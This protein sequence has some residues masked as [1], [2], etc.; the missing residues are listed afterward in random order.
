MRDHHLSPAIGL[1]Y[2]PFSNSIFQITS[3]IKSVING[4]KNVVFNYNVG[5]LL[6]LS[7]INF[8]YALEKSEFYQQDFNHFFSVGIRY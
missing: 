6:S 2:N 8:S 1:T 7:E 5:L 3:G 4:Y